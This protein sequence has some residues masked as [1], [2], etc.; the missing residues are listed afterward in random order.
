MSSRFLPAIPSECLPCERP[1]ELVA[2]IAARD[3]VRGLFKVVLDR[4]VSAA[5][6][7]ENDPAPTD[8]T[9]PTIAA[10]SRND[11]GISES[12]AERIRTSARA[13]VLVALASGEL[14]SFVQC[15]ASNGFYRVPTDF[16]QW[17]SACNFTK[18]SALPKAYEASPF[19][20]PSEE[21]YIGLTLM[22][23]KADGDSLVG[24]A[25]LRPSV[26]TS[27]VYTPPTTNSQPSGTTGN[28]VPIAT[29]Q[30]GL[31]GRPSTL[32]HC[33]K[34]MRERHSAGLTLDTQTAEAK[35]IVA[36]FR[37]DGRFNHLPP[38]AWP[39]VKNGLKDLYKQLT[40]EITWPT[41]ERDQ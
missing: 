5:D 6:P 25:V 41:L 30:N 22:I 27:F 11:A 26:S 3:G 19:D 35:A 29:N 13:A 21:K 28:V 17:W 32:I 1:G 20:G 40:G 12:E 24:N 18:D 33:E 31:Q 4:P 37:V 7:S 2:R 15:G 38:P 10:Y 16:W 34:L 36:A 9:V 23:A 14:G 8:R 39:T